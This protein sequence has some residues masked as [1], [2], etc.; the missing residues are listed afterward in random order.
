MN[1]PTIHKIEFATLVGQ[2][3]RHAGCN[4]RL[5]NHGLNVRVSL[6][7]ITLDD[8]RTGF[9]PS[10]A[11]REH[12]SALLGQPLSAVFDA[13]QGTAPTPAARVLDYA[14]WDLAGQMQ[15]QPVYALAAAIQGKPIPKALSVRCYDTS[16]YFDDLQ[17]ASHEEA[18]ALIADEAR[19][20]WARG[21]RAFKIKVGRGA[22]HLPVEEGT[23]RDIA[24]IQAVR[25]AVGPDAPIMIDANNGYTLNLAKR[26]L[27]ETAAC[28]IFWLEEAF[29]EDRVLYED[30]RQWMQ[31]NGIATL[32]ADGEGDAS[33]RLMDWARD[34]IVDVLQYDYMDRGFTDWL[35]LGKQLDEWRVRSAPHHYGGHVGNYLC[36]HFA[37]AIQGFTFVE[38]DEAATPGIQAP[39]YAVVD[40]QVQVPTQP[41][42]G[43]QLDEDAFQ[44]ALRE[45]GWSV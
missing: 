24:I 26:V 4:A 31:A 9:G 30:L 10:R 13:S 17:C 14:L 21:H 42:F 33:P 7:R 2:R 8:G 45:N 36:A 20:G 28:K 3:P 35:A 41:G 32:I 37:A 15:E 12:A 1:K 40:G 43:L 22:R 38:W 34:G 11:T 19:Q 39:G 5:G 44:S 23:R 18:A 6:A 25:A 29:H 16:L 27:S